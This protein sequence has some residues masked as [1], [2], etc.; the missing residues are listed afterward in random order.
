M[1]EQNSIN[2]FYDEFEA[3]LYDWRELEAKVFRYILDNPLHF[4]L[5]HFRD[6]DECADFLG[7]MYPRLSASIKKYVRNKATFDTYINSV[8]RYAIKEYR[9][10][11]YN[12]YE[13][14]SNAWDE[15][16]HELYVEENEMA[17]GPPV[18]IKETPGNHEKLRN[19]KQMLILLLKT[20]YFLNDDIVSRVASLIDIQEDEIYDKIHKLRQVRMK[21]EARI[22]MLCEHSSAQYFRYIK[23]EKRLRTL[24][25]GSPHYNG[26]KARI[27]MQRTRLYR[28]RQRLRRIRC[29]ASN[30]QIAQVLGLSKSTVDATM[31][32][33]K[34]N[35]SKV[36]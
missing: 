13:S 15:K 9:S 24:E 12:F 27:R 7:W 22:K 4:G 1:N 16:S 28:I 5:G 14:E 32:C 26:I 3:E 19:A 17:Y 36:S 2:H 29:N 35:A 33:I 25:K 20:Y 21:T 11:Q 31:S 30:L 18:T 6:R 8:I 34:N 10:K 23:N